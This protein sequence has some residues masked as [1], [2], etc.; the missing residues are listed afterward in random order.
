MLEEINNSHHNVAKS[1]CEFLMNQNQ[2]I[3]THFD[4]HSSVARAEYKQKLQTIIVIVKYLLI[5]GQAFCGHNESESLLNRDNYL[6]FWKALGEIHADF[7]KLWDN[8][9]KNN[10]LSSSTVQ[11]Q[12]CRCAAEETTKKL[13]EKLNDSYFSLLLDEA[14]DISTKERMTPRR[15]QLD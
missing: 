4:R 9:P 11:K 2:H 12:I 8:A 7:K 14:R 13:I 1:K 5:Y 6:G 15:E 3:E 10:T